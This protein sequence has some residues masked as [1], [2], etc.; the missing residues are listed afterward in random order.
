MFHLPNELLIY[1]YNFDPTCY[2][3][4]DKCMEELKKKHKYEQVVMSY[5]SSETI[6]PK[7]LNWL[8]ETYPIY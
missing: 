5:Y 1:I 4:Y 7:W 3:N 8:D 2:K 6:P